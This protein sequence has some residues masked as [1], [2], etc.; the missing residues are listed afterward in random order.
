M[1]S[2]PPTAAG[3]DELRSERLGSW[4]WAV[5]ARAGHPAFDDWSV[6]AWSAHP[7][8]QVR[9]SLLEGRGPTDRRATELGIPRVVGAVVPHFSMA[10]PVLAQ[11][12]FLLT[13][14][15]VTMGSA[16]EPRQLESREVPFDLPD[17]GLSLFRN[18]AEGSEPGVRW[19][20]ER[21]AAAFDGLGER[22]RHTQ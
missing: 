4:S 18:A 22:R 12:D 13:A 2:S 19:F 5:Y 3:S 6:G 15:S 9:T 17:F 20:L 14:P 1:H 11:T 16:A 10:A 8:L 21:V 7:H